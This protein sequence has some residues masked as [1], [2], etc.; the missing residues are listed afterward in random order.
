MTYKL[1]ELAPENHNSQEFLDFL[2]SNNTV[3]FENEVWLV[4]ENCKYHKPESKHHTAF[5]KSNQG[6]FIMQDDHYKA[7]KS[8]I[9][10]MGYTQ[11]AMLIK[12][13][14]DRTVKRFHVHFIEKTV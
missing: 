5:L 10:A 9:I 3:V 14:Q 2:R 7:L 12:R 11:W 1:L 8:V 13:P 4:I 6:W